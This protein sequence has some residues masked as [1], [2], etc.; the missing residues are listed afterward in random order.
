MGI[1]RK[2]KMVQKEY[3]VAGYFISIEDGGSKY[4]HNILLGLK[5]GTGRQSST[6]FPLDSAMLG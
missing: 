1:A 2:I 6:P 4:L 3:F 5:K